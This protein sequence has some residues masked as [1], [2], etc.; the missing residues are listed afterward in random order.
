ML[1]VIKRFLP[2]ALVAFIF[3]L[4]QG[5]TKLDTTSL[6]SD[7]IPAVDNVKTFRDSFDITTT[8]GI[9][10]DSFKIFN[11]EN[12]VL[13]L[14]TNDPLFGATEANIFLQLKPGFF[15][16]HFANAG[17]TIV[18]VDS[19]VL[20]L[21]FKG[22]W[23]DTNVL[24]RL[25]VYEIS[26]PSFGDSVFKYKDIKYQPL[27]GAMV[28]SAIVDIRELNDKK[29]IAGGKDSVTNQ[30][31]IKLNNTFTSVLAARDSLSVS[32]TGNN[33]FRSDSVFR[34]AYKGLAVKATGSGNA[35]MY[36]NL[37]DV[38]TRLE[39]HLRKKNAGTGK[40][41][42]IYN[43]FK[44]NNND[45]GTNFP[46]ASS[47][48]IK[49]F[50]LSNVTNPL[51]QD[52][53][54]QTGPGT[55][56]NLNIPALTG[57][58]NRIV[59][60]AQIYMEQDPEDIIY[61][62]LFSAPPYM[63]LDLIDTGSTKWKPVYFDLNPST[64]YDPDNKNGYPYF[65]G[66]AKVDYNYFGGFARTRLNAIGE[67]VVYYEINIT[68]HVQQIATRGTINYSMRL[69]PAYRLF[70]PQYPGASAISYDNPL[71]FGRVKLKSGTHPYKPGRMQ[72]IMTWSKL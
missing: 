65:P 39:I 21:S 42:T 67:K 47:N 55:Y 36:I 3:I 8:Q 51:P 38:S 43:S 12:N 22:A 16:Y 40:L 34:K 31:R 19:V 37:T 72:L 56:A 66:D 10:A 25:E 9:F 52:L 2:I 1:F 50:Y 58:S 70:Y 7:L 6:G 23:G 26:D 18:G 32:P 20:G 54:L 24:Q 59:H 14:I 64:P 27:L 61:D 5:C 57:L 63:Y 28:G 15:P 53:Y 48:Y 30:I 69:F 29:I 33:A 49:R 62:S 13:G 41:D 11:S 4:H 35:L 68:R 71:A 45:L 17:D 44:I 46:S 60:R